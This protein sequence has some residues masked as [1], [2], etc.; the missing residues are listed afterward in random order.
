MLSSAVKL[1]VRWQEERK[2]R[3]VVQCTSNQLKQKHTKKQKEI[4]SACL[5]SF[6]FFIYYE[7]AVA[8]AELKYKLFHLHKLHSN[9]WG[10]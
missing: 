6:V 1:G 3:T 7:M 5:F 2:K 10:T 9:D 8:S 4:K